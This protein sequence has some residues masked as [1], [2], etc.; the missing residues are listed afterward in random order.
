MTAARAGHTFDEWWATEPTLYPENLKRSAKVAWDAAREEWRTGEP[1]TPEW[2]L[3]TALYPHHEEGQPDR[4]RWVAYWNGSSWN[5]AYEV[6]A[7]TTLPAPYT[8]KE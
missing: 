5:T 7:W 4:F 2:Y 6:V 1:P 3:T 8:P